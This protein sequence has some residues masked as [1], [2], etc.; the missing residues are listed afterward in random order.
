MS[1]TRMPE[2]ADG[3]PAGPCGGLV[4]LTVTD[5]VVPALTGREGCRYESPP[6]T[7]AQAMALAWLLLGHPVDQDGERQWTAPIAGGQRLVTLT[8]ETTQ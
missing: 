3:H 8:E 6:Q 5:T 7:H 4:V 1:G 2:R